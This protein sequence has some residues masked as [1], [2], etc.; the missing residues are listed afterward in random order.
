ML[1][2]GYSRVFNF[3]LK[4]TLLVASN[5]ILR[6]LIGELSRLILITLNIK[7]KI[8]SGNIRADKSDATTT[9]RLTWI[10]MLG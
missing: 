10:Y 8:V 6:Q 1:M 9:S 4:T 3:I 5:I 2:W 7:D